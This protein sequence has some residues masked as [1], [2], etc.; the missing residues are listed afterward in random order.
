M[1]DSFL[2]R[3]LHGEH[4][5]ANPDFSLIKEYPSSRHLL[6]QYRHSLRNNSGVI[7]LPVWDTCHLWP[8]ARAGGVLR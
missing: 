6:S 3:D 7:V 4:V 8:I 1:V 5:Y 2:N